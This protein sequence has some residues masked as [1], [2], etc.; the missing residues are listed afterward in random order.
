MFT[1]GIQTFEMG[2]QYKCATVIQLYGDVTTS[3]KCLFFYSVAVFQLF[4]KY[5]AVYESLGELYI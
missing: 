3:G 1:F 2:E 5:H 4:V